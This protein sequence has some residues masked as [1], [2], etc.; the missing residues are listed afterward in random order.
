MKKCSSSIWHWDLN[1]QPSERDPPPKTTRPGLPPMLKIVSTNVPLG[2]G[3]GSSRK[4]VTS[5]VKGR[6]FESRHGRILKLYT[7]NC[8]AKMK[9][10]K[11]VL[12]TETP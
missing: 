10:K 12:C 4:A 6:R 11:K 3:F 7:L 8:I 2:S 5:D 9:V 1:I